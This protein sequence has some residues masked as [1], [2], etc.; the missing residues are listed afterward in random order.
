MKKLSLILTV[1]TVGIIAI[2]FSQTESRDITREEVKQ[3]FDK[4][5]IPVITEERKS[6]DKALSDSEKDVIEIARQKVKVRKLMFKN[7]Y[8]SEDFVAGQRAKDPNFNVMREDMQKSMTEVRE[9]AIAHSTE[10][11]EYTSNIRSHADKWMTEILTIAEKN[12]QDPEYVLKMVRQHMRKSNTPI[13]FLLFN[14]DEAGHTDFFEMDNKLK[15]IVYP[16]PVVRSATIAII[17]AAD[18][19]IQVTLYTK[20]GETLSTLFN[21]INSDQRLE[22]ILN[23]TE[24]NNDIYIVKVVIDDA[25]I[26]RKVV[27]NH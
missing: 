18:K 17:G 9:I 22:V 15:V 19:N 5:I 3:Y 20:D 8:E 11:R 21:G 16:N 26:S 1:I 23:S 24:L 14:P 25:E 2:A 7:W 4:N 13:A 10:I 27:V 6:F 12:N